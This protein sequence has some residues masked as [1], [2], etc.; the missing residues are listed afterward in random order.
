MNGLGPKVPHFDWYGLATYYFKKLNFNDAP[1]H[2]LWFC[3][4]IL[5][6][7][8]NRIFHF[9]P[10]FDIVPIKLW[11]HFHAT[12]YMLHATCYML[13]TTCYILHTNF[14]QKNLDP[15]LM[16]FVN[17]SSMNM[18]VCNHVCFY[19]NDRTELFTMS[20]LTLE[21]YSSLVLLP[22]HGTVYLGGLW[23]RFKWCVSMLWM[24][25]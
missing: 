18:I 14:I 2:H 6:K 23:F 3:R 22:I 16:D 12:C 8:W 20:S 24:F 9:R 11:L 10:K 7:I 25:L 17:I 13:H 5:R 19:V 1:K 21:I 15:V 4:K